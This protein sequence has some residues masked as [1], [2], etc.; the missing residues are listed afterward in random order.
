MSRAKWIQFE[1]A[2][3][4]LI[5]RNLSQKEYEREV[6]RLLKKYKI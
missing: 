2:K 3:Q 1:S 5:R 6:R 4:E